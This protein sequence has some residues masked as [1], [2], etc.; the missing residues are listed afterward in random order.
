MGLKWSFFPTNPLLLGYETCICTRLVWDSWRIS[1]EKVVATVLIILGPHIDLFFIFKVKILVLI[2]RSCSIEVSIIDYLKDYVS[3][4]EKYKAE[5][6][7]SPCRKI[8]IRRTAVFTWFYSLNWNYCEFL[9]PEVCMNTVRMSRFCNSFSLW[10]E[11][12][13]TLALL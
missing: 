2:I 5:Q 12:L 6:F 11:F 9:K 13:L 3:Y 7:F 4:M 1:Y 8:E 10:D